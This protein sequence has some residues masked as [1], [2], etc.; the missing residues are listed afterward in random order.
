MRRPRPERET[1][2]YFAQPAKSA[3]GQH[4]IKSDGGQKQR[5]ARENREQ[6]CQE[7][8][9]RPRLRDA[10]RHRPNVEERLGR[11][12]AIDDFTNRFFEPLHVAGSADEQ[13]QVRA[14]DLRLRKEKRRRRLGVV[15]SAELQVRHHAD[16]FVKP[17]TVPHD[18]GFR[19]DQKPFPERILSLERQV[20]EGLVDD[21]DRRR[22]GAVMFV[23][24]AST[25]EVDLHRRE[26][27]AGHHLVIAGG[28]LAG[29]DRRRAFRG[30]VYLPAADHG[31]VR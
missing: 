26:I 16:D 18:I 2:R 3:V 8:M 31:R 27:I 14:P 21:H 7:A 15:V 6:E 30:E 20:G 29:I 9:R 1:D 22:I 23:E 5:Q 19:V 28:L 11:I 4:A 17:W 24:D 12:E 13:N 25:D 10:F